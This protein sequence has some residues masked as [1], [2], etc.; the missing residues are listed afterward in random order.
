[1]TKQGYT[2]II[3]PISKANAGPQLARTAAVTL[4]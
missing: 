2:F 1:M 3:V 4:R